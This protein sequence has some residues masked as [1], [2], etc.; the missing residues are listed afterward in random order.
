MSPASYRAA[1]PRVGEPDST[2]PVAQTPNRVARSLLDGPD[3]LNRAGLEAL[4]LR[5]REARR[6]DVRELT[7]GQVLA[8]RAGGDLVDQPLGGVQRW[9]AAADV[10]E[11]E[12]P[13]AGDQ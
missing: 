5:D 11:Q 12:Q 2:G 4:P 13:A 7:T 9:P 10:V 1:P 6:L 3:P 8:G